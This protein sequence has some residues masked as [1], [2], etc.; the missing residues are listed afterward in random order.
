MLQRL[1]RSWFAYLFAGISLVVGYHAIAHALNAG[2]V[3]QPNWS[4]PMQASALVTTPDHLLIPHQDRNGDP[5]SLQALDP[6]TGELQWQSDQAVGQ[7]F[8]LAGDTI[9][10]NDYGPMPLVD[11]PKHVVTLDAKTGQTNAIWPIDNPDFEGII[12]AYQGAFILNTRIR[13]GTETD[14]YEI[15][16]QTADTVRWTF[17]TPPDSLVTT[18]SSRDSISPFVQDGIVILPIL[19]NPQTDQRGYQIVGLDAATGAVLW[20][21]QTSSEI[22]H[23]AVLGD[24]VYPSVYGA[25]QANP[26]WVKAL[27]LKTGAERWTY[28]MLG[29]HARAV[30][31]QEVLIWSLW[32]DA[33]Q[34]NRLLLLDRQTGTLKRQLVLS[35]EYDTEATTVLFANDVIY[36]D[37]MSFGHTIPVPG[38][39]GTAENN[40]WIG[41]FDATNGHLLWRTPT[42]SQS[43]IYQFV[44]TN[45]HL[46]VKSNGLQPDVKSVVQQYSLHQR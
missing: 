13:Q 43:H 37:D 40:S 8:A 9:Y 14:R 29:G 4:V 5:L 11:A 35:R 24:A 15:S 18:F 30:S 45:D 10:A 33:D 2:L 20:T 44:L 32:F 7:I 28:P 23:I 27:D 42:L 39:Y 41:A 6:A 38:F 46:L 1:S 3:Q 21:W 12:G 34:P 19:V 31:D 17:T 16:A 36:A 22:E 26:G 25:D